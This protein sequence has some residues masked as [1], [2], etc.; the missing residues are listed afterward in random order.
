MQK[1]GEVLVKKIQEIRSVPLTKKSRPRNLDWEQ[2]QQVANYL[3][4]RP[5]FVYKLFKKYGRGKVI[6]MQSYMKDLPPTSNL[7]AAL[8]HQLS[9]T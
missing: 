2:A 1:I 8:Q 9:T 6:S 5:S 4:I 3:K 7:Y